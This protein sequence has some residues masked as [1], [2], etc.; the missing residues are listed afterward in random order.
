MILSREQIE[1][2][3]VSVTDEFSKTYRKRRRRHYYDPIDAVPIEKFAT[4][5]LGLEILFAPL[6]IDGSICGLT[7][8]IDTEYRYELDGKT[9]VLPLKQNQI[10]LDSRFNQPNQTPSLRARGRFTLA[11]ECV[12]Q[13][14]FHLEAD[15]VQDACKRQ[16]SE[17]RPYSLRELK[18]REDWNEWQANVLGAAILM[19]KDE[20][21]QTMQDGFGQ[22]YKIVSYGG[23]FRRC[24]RWKLKD[25]CK[26]LEVSM[27]AAIIRLRDLGYLEE[28]IPEAYLDSLEGI[29]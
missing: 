21:R 28:Y 3:A 5:F 1:E 25:I 22:I 27:P 23:D 11:H 7:T 26:M 20:I 2:I 16:Y 12:H 9:V 18:T 6:S 10:V 4:D 29:G 15:D 17:R 24:D 14:L 13:L 19:P 8:Y